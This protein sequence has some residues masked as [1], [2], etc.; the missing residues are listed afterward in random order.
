MKLIV[1]YKAKVYSTADKKKLSDGS[2]KTYAYGA[3]NLRAPQ[4]K[5]FVGKKVIVK[6]FNDETGG[7]K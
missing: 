2:S 1:T 3:I 5:A 7:R 6:V 4:L